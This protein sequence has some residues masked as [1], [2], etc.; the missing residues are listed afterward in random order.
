MQ[1]TNVLLIFID[2][3]GIGERN[4]ANPLAQIENAAPLAHFIGENKQE[5]YDGILIPTDASLGVEGRPQSASGQTTILTGKNA[6]QILGFHKQGFPNQILRDVLQEHSIFKQLKNLNIEP[7]VFAN[8]YTPQFFEQTPRWKSATTCAVE[9]ADLR[10]N[11]LPDLLKEKALFHDF[12]NHFLVER[13]FDVPIYSPK[14]AAEILA[15]ITENHRFTL[16]EHFIT[17]KIGHA[18]DFDAAYKHL[19]ILAE[20]VRAVLEKI[21]FEKTTVILTSDHGNVENLSI[22]NH[23]LN[24]VP[25]VIWGKN[26]NEASMKIKDLTDITPTIISLLRN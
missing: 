23:T 16:Y 10:F 9:A 25:T 12:T 13:G 6:P 17:D 15:R 3:L 19:P 11:R 24:K 20:F 21:D 26:K 7:N 14:T 1:E 2:G 18:Q 22:R 4:D 8:I 5:I